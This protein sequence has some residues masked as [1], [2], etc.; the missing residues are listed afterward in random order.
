MFDFRNV[1]LLSPYVPD[2]KDGDEGERENASRNEG[3][4]TRG[5]CANAW[6]VREKN[7]KVLRTTKI[8]TL[9]GRR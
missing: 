8:T 4:E 9:E 7:G 3:R 1:K 5:G 2:S 6:V